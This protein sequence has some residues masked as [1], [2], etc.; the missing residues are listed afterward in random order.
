MKKSIIAFAS[1][2]LVCTTFFLSCETKNQAEVEELE[3]ALEVPPK[4]IS[5]TQ[6]ATLFQ[7]D[8]NTRLSQIGKE[9]TR[10]EDK[11]IHFDLVTLEKCVNRLEGLKASKNIPVTGV[12]FVFGA[13]AN[14][15]RT[16]FLMPSTRN[17][18][19]DYHE[20]FTIEND[21]FLTFTQIAT[22]LN[23][24]N[25][26]QNDADLILS[27]NGYLSFNE[28]IELFNNY[29]NQYIE[30]FA[31]KVKKEYYTKAIWYSF[32]EIKGYIN[33]LKTKSTDHNLSITGVNIFFG[34]YNN[35]PSLELKSNT[36][37]LFFTAS[38]QQG[39]I[40][41]IK[42]ET[43]QSF[44]QKTFFSK[45]NDHDTNGSLNFNEAEAAPPPPCLPGCQSGC[46]C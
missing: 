38:T 22:K 7:N 13:D 9:N 2:G 23:S 34:V 3:T 16:T 37:T 46:Y 42:G 27:T 30:P 35:D 25:D 31:K 14:G 17:A 8:Q 20:A 1:L 36:Q 6:A 44:I 29:E 40:M 39:S 19:L 4:I 15:N 43:L 10:F 24:I 26:S 11:A 33:Y 12:S 5:N 32:K 28:A 45:E 18:E 21:Q 41:N